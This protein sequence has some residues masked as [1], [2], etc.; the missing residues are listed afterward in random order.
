MNK[1]SGDCICNT[2]LYTPKVWKH[3]QSYWC[4]LNPKKIYIHKWNIILNQEHNEYSISLLHNTLC[5][6]YIMSHVCLMPVLCIHSVVSMPMTRAK[7]SLVS[8][9]VSVT[10]TDWYLVYLP[11]SL[12]VCV[13]SHGSKVTVRLYRNGNQSRWLSYEE[14][15]KFLNIIQ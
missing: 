7:S 1:S 5:T 10:I 11:V 3:I 2:K 8:Q 4:F 9:S 13:S 15:I 6:S 14:T 12:I